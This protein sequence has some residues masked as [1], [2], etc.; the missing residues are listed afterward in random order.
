MIAIILNHHTIE[1]WN[2]K[3]EVYQPLTSFSNASLSKKIYVF[4]IIMRKKLPQHMSISSNV[5]DIFGKL[6]GIY[7]KLILKDFKA[8]GHAGK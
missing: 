5:L 3:A 8:E 7:R 6:C 4:L 2:F 1:Y